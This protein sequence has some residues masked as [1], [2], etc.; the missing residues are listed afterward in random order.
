MIKRAT[1]ESMQ[2]SLSALTAVAFVCSAKASLY[3]QMLEFLFFQAS[4]SALISDVSR[5]DGTSGAKKIRGQQLT[6][7]VLLI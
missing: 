5:S 4:G 7:H 6:V 1:S 2:I 3:L